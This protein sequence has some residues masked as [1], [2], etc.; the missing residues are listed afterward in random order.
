M[1]YNSNLPTDVNVTVSTA[2]IRENFRALKEDK[3]VAAATAVLAESAEKLANA[4]AISLNGDA[5][6]S[7]S[8][9]GAADV[10]ITVD[11]LDADTVDGLHASDLIK[12]VTPVGTVIWYASSTPPAGY[13]E[14]DG[15]VLSATDYPALVAVLGTTYGVNGQLPDLRGRFIRGWDHSRIFG[16]L[17][18]DAGRNVTG[19]LY[20]VQNFVYSSGDGA[21]ANGSFLGQSN[22]VHGANSS[23][24][25]YSFDASRVWGAS[26]TAN[27]FRPINVA[28]LACIKY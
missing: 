26:H 25:N 16:N 6:G 17:E 4:R 9:D 22:V 27:E 21:F 7:A 11:V 1:S 14:C 18:Q 2:D 15:E 8:F 10:N 19:N 23:G 3:I 5:V 24:Y 13:L 20:G 28:L 12:A